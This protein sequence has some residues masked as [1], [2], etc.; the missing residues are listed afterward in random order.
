MGNEKDK[1]SVGKHVFEADFFMSCTSY[2][3]IW[4]IRI[5]SCQVDRENSIFARE[6]RVWAVGKTLFA[7]SKA[8]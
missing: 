8:V 5:E 2:C 4:A 7:L 6:G 3:T 1:G